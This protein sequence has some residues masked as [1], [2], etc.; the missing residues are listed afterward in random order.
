[1]RKG[2]PVSRDAYCCLLGFCTH[3]SSGLLRNISFKLVESVHRCLS[4]N[5]RHVTPAC[6]SAFRQEVRRW[7]L[8]SSAQG[9]SSQQDEGWVLQRPVALMMR[10]AG[11]LVEKQGA[12]RKTLNPSP[13]WTCYHSLTLPGRRLVLPH[14]PLGGG[15]VANA[16]SSDVPLSLCFI[17]ALSRCNEEE[18]IREGA[19]KLNA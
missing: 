6:Q 5:I 16:A 15:G 14:R 4:G 13:K 9:K 12:K 11:A 17:M 8:L 3:C 10:L 2:L 19:K 1:M 7:D 18:R